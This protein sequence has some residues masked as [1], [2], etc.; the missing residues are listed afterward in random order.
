MTPGKNPGGQ[1]P[2]LII[3]DEVD[4]LF[5]DRALQGS[6]ATLSEYLRIFKTLRALAQTHQCLVT[7]L[8]AY[9]PHINR[10]NL[11]SPAVG[12][13]PM[14]KSFQ[15]EYLGFLDEPDSTRMIREIGGWKDIAWDKEAARKV[16]Y[17]CGGHPLVTR[18]FASMACEEGFRKN[19][20]MERVE[21]TALNLQKTFRK[22]QIG[23]YYKEGVWALMEDGEREVLSRICKAVDREITEED[24]PPELEEALTSLEHFGLV[25]NHNGSLCLAANLFNAW[26]KRSLGI[27]H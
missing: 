8:I 22:N 9:R 17:Y 15:E 24:I 13:N 20:D 12:E 19:I 10:F 23:N 4:K 1:E 6:E 11:L 26:L 2:F 5:P 7:L 21:E 18:Y 27:C 16:F 14:F 3:L 25:V